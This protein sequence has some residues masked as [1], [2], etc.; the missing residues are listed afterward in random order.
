MTRPPHDGA[1]TP[2]IAHARGRLMASDDLR[3]RLLGL[4][5]DALQQ[6]AAALPSVD[7]GLL[8]LVGDCSAALAA[9][10]AEPVEPL[11]LRGHTEIPA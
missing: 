1:D 4:R 8:R 7:T 3:D 6:L 10:D 9:L 11:P 2:D 5:R